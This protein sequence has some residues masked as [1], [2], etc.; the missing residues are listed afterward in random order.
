MIG[1]CSE[2][3]VLE[4]PELVAEVKRTLADMLEKYS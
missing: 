4:P 3:T 1:L 2:A